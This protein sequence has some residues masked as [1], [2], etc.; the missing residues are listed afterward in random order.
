[1]ALLGFLQGLCDLCVAGLHQY[2]QWG[3]AG[4]LVPPP[5]LGCRSVGAGPQTGLT[6]ASTGRAIARVSWVSAHPCVKWPGA[7]LDTSHV[8][9]LQTW[10]RL[11]KG[12]C[13]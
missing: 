2:G 8:L 4:S 11:P 10:Q 3:E 5:T 1:M 12:T 7:G 13:L 9:P 6:T